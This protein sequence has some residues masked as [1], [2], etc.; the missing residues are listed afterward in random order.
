MKQNHSLL[1]GVAIGLFCSLTVLT[2]GYVA[3]VF[4]G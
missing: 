4:A 2:A 1:L 3:G